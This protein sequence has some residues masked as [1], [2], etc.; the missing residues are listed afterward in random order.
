M[1]VK[2][3]R[4]ILNNNKKEIDN[5]ELAIPLNGEKG[6]CITPFVSI[7]SVLPGFDWDNGKLFIIP[8]QALRR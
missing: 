2:E 6:V 8:K 3:L 5:L 4:K 7:E 1:K